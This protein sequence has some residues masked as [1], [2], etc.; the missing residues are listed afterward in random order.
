MSSEDNTTG[1]SVTDEVVTLVL[2]TG[3]KFERI[4]VCNKEA[5]L[6]QFLDN[7]LKT[8]EVS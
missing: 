8:L 3:E 1:N 4:P 2:E 5:T 7:A 6:E